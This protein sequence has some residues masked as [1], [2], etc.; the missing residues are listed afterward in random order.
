MYL[1]N[2]LENVKIEAMIIISGGTKLTP[3]RELY[4]DTE[5]SKLKDKRENHKL[6]QLFKMQNDITLHL[7]QL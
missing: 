4:K 7:Y 6:I 3:L 2:N 1:I 5:L